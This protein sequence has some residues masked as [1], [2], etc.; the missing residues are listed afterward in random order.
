MNDKPQWVIS[1]YAPETG[2][3]WEVT[4]ETETA[5]KVDTEEYFFWLPKSE[6]IPTTPPERWEDIPFHISPAVAGILQG[7][8]E[9]GQRVI[10]ADGKLVLQRRKE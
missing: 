8:C 1:K 3:K 4:G 2:E 6:Y 9:I 5:W 10:E 7:F